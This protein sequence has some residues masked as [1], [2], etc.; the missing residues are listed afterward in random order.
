MDRVIVTIKRDGD[1]QSRDLEVPTNMPIRQMA[2]IISRS[3]GWEMDA[4]GRHVQFQVAAQPPGR[5]LQDT[6]TLADVEAWD[7]AWLIFYEAKNRAGSVSR[8]TPGEQVLT[9]QV[10]SWTPLNIPQANQNAPVDPQP[11]T[12]NSPVAKPSGSGGWKQLDD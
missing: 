5:I 9:G 10:G 7:G 6:E 12:G 3:L 8:S 1:N 2:A 11:G 4:Q